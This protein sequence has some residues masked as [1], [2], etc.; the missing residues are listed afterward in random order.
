MDTGE[1][2]FRAF[3]ADNPTEFKSKVDELHKLYPGHG[4]IFKEGE[5]VELKGS[6]FVISKILQNGLKLKLLSS[7]DR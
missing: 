6:S 4:G 2:K 3:T 5:K 1:G 7:G